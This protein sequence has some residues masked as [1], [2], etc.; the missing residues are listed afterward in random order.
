MAQ[1]GVKIEGLDQLNRKLKGLAKLYPEATTKG[2][3]K[4]GLQISGDAKQSAPVDSGRLRGSIT[5]SIGGRQYGYQST[6]DSESGDKM[7]VQ[8]DKQTLV[9]GTNVAYARKQEYN[10][11]SPH[12][13]YLTKAVQ[14]NQGDVIDFIV[15]EIQKA[16]KRGAK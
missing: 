15:D 3:I 7:D 5:Y 10:E 14:A 2:L 6:G 12:S 4:S 1:A 8:T 11:N 13:H 16:T 9:V